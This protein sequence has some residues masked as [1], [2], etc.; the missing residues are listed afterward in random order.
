M[1]SGQPEPRHPADV[2]RDGT[3]DQRWSAARALGAGTLGAGTLGASTLG[4]STVGAQRAGDTSGV[5][6]AA[7]DAVV[8]L[9]NALRTEADP[10]VRQAIFTGLVRL[11][12]PACVEAVIPCLRVDD[13]QLRGAALDALRAMIGVVRPMLPALLADPDA[14]VRLLSCDLAREL[15]TSD[16]TRLLCDVLAR[17]TEP[18]VCAA[19]VDVLA[20]IGDAE[21]LPFLEACAGRFGDVTFL[22]FAVRIAMQRIVAERPAPHAGAV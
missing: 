2:L 6:P 1:P 13:P 4:A 18:N 22:G 21:A 17:D 10:R 5:G 15:S 14:D 19:A 8:A 20:E 3:A 9:A 12:S 7:V 16:A 11:G